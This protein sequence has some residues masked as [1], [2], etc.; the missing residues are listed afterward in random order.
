MGRSSTVSC[1]RTWNGTKE[2][3]GLRRDGETDVAAREALPNFAASPAEDGRKGEKDFSRFDGRVADAEGIGCV[4]GVVLNRRRRIFRYFA[5]LV[6]RDPL[7]VEILRYRSGRDS[8]KNGETPAFQLIQIP[9]GKSHG[10][11]DAG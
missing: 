10:A 8:K 7:S 4:G 6:D 5:V 2:R 1:T 9:V 3:R 11:A